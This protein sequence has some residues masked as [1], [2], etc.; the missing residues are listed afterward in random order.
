MGEPER[1]NPWVAVAASGIGFVIG[2]LI[3]IGLSNRGNPPFV[4]PISYPITLV[5][6]GG[7]LLVL[8]IRLRRAVRHRPGDVNPFHAVRLLATAR[9]GLLVGALSLGFGLGMLAS[10]SG[11]TI[12]APASTWAP[13][14]AVALGSAIL[15]ACAAIAES[16]CR[17]PPGDDGS[18]DGDADQPPG[19]GPLDQPAFRTR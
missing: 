7:L 4:P 6:V 10:L 2:L 5:L 17:V 16:L 14:L 11:R 3:E 9:A 18:G 1:R 19:P 8:G 15:I 12:A 13:M